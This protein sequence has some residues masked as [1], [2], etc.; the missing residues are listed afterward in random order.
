MLGANDPISW[1]LFLT[2]AI[3]AMSVRL[4]VFEFDFDPEDSESLNPP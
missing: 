3:Y 1:S 2:K 4:Q